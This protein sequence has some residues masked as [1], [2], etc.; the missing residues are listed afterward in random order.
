MEKICPTCKKSF[1]HGD[2]RGQA[3][4]YCTYRCRDA[5]QAARVQTDRETWRICGHPD[6]ENRARSSRATLC[7]MHYGRVRRYGATDPSSCRYCEGPKR[8]ERSVYCSRT[9]S[10]RAARARQYGMTPAQARAFEATR[11]N[12]CDICG[13]SPGIKGLHWDHDH[14]TGAL[15]GLL[16]TTC[17]SGLGF[18]RDSPVVLRL[19]AEYLG[20]G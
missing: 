4:K 16:C 7:E 8:H 5:A 20:P 12:R 13:G 2:R 15:R 11:Q 6:C 9:C 10:N 3:R 14:E 1:T 18:F 19:A 17:N